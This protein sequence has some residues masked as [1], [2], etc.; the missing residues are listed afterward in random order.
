[1]FKCNKRCI[2]RVSTFTFKKHFYFLFRNKFSFCF[3][4]IETA[5]KPL[6]VSQY[7]PIPNFFGW[8]RER[9]IEDTLGDVIKHSS[10]CAVTGFP[11]WNALLHHSKK[12][13][14]LSPLTPKSPGY[15]SFLHSLKSHACSVHLV[16]LN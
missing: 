10:T 13:L 15:S 7:F 1:M 12:V 14:R 16:T 2:N 11:E 6:G 8:A 5:D 3:V 9:L 4:V